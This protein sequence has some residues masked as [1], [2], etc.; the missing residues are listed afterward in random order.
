[1]SSILGWRRLPSKTKAE[2]NQKASRKV[3]RKLSVQALALPRPKKVMWNVGIRM[4]EVTAEVK[5]ELEVL[6]P[7]VGIVYHAVFWRPGVAVVDPPASPKPLQHR[8]TRE[9]KAR[10]SQQA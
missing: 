6:R 4:A 7:S 8:C 3:Q 5:L 10:S 1:M 2:Y 9:L